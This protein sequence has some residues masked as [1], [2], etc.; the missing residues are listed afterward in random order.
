MRSA[1]GSHEVYLFGSMWLCRVALTSVLRVNSQ[2][3]SATRRSRPDNRRQSPHLFL[4]FSFCKPLHVRH[5]QVQLAVMHLPGIVIENISS[6]WAPVS[7]TV[8]LARA[9]PFPSY[10]HLHLFS[11]KSNSTP[12]TPHTTHRQR[13]SDPIPTNREQPVNEPGSG[14]Q[15]VRDVTVFDI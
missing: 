11:P 12:T 2:S 14:C 7:G 3:H 1:F 9:L 8:S 4:G 5:V 10:L 6:L 15:S 13:C